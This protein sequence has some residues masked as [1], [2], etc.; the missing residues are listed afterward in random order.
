M[1]GRF[2]ADFSGSVKEKL[3]FDIVTLQLDSFPSMWTATRRV[4]HQVAEATLKYARLMSRSIPSVCGGGGFGYSGDHD[5]K[6]LAEQTGGRV[7][8]V[9][10]KY[11][12]L[13][14]GFDQI[15]NELRSQY[16]IGYTP[17]NAKRDGTFRRVEIRS[18]EGHKIQARRGY[19]SLQQ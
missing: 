3:Y 4:S 15:Q 1:P 18:K 17:T 8:E 9:G 6:E 5:M 14:E 10:N 19:Y 11:E 12:K 16:S 7:I 13:K 2:K